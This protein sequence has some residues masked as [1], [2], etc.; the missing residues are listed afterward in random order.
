MIFS[1]DKKDGTVYCA[2]GEHLCL[3]SA[4][5]SKI[6]RL[7]CTDN[8]AHIISNLLKEDMISALVCV[9]TILSSYTTAGHNLL[10]DL[11]YCKIHKVHHMREYFE[12]SCADYDNFLTAK[13]E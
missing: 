9:K 2:G 4:P 1:K 12:G 13:K 3:P 5:N 7:L 11:K 10:S 8:R 6:M